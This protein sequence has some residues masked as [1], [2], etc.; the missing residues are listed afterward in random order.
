MAFVTIL[1]K[2]IKIAGLGI[3]EIDWSRM[4]ELLANKGITSELVFQA[5]LIP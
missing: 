2:K 1:P 3:N 4:D 5:I